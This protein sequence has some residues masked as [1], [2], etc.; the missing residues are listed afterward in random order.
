MDLALAFIV[1][2][3]FALAPLTSDSRHANQDL[4]QVGSDAGSGSGWG[5]SG[6]PLSLTH[7][8]FR[9]SM[10]TTSGSTLLPDYVSE[11]PKY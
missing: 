6:I 10:E 4:I 1:L 9:V 2:A 7:L 11:N 5:T 3:L 8:L